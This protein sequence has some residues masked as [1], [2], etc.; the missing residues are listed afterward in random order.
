[1]KTKVRIIKHRPNRNSFD[2]QEYQ[3]LQLQFLVQRYKT[4]SRSLEEAFSIQ[5]QSSGGNPEW[6]GMSFICH[7]DNYEHIKYMAKVA[8][9]IEKANLY[10]TEKT[11]EVI[12][13]IL[14]CERHVYDQG[15]FVPE[16]MSGCKFY[17]VIKDGKHWSSIHAMTEAGAYKILDETVSKE[18]RNGN[19]SWSLEL[20]I[21]KVV[22][23]ITD[24]KS[25][26]T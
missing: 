26:L 13:N 18:N 24:V 6:Y 16:S 3:H 21:E 1:M 9:E 10:Y 4:H 22:F 14:N 19:S 23:N 25:D 20:S 11:P 5:W 8:T 7:T 17:V 2:G 12:M 15:I